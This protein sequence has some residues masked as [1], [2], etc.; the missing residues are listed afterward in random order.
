[1]DEAEQEVIVEKVVSKT[2]MKISGHCYGLDYK[3]GYLRSQKKKS[4]TGGQDC[5]LQLA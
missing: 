4:R 1:L 5:C 2:R 3:S